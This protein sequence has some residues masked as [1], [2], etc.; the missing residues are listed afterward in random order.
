MEVIQCFHTA[1][2]DKIAVDTALNIAFTGSAPARLENERGAVHVDLH[3]DFQDS[4][5]CW[6]APSTG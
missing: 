4:S 3:H 6:L 1:G 5:I 2:L